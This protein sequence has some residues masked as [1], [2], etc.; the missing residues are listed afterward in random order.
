MVAPGPRKL[1]REHEM[2]NRLRHVPDEVFSRFI[3]FSDAHPNI[4]PPGYMLQKVTM[5]DFV[6]PLVAASKH[7][8][9]LEIGCG[10]G[11][12]SALLSGLGRVTSTELAVPGSFAGADDDVDRHRN[13]VFEALAKGPIDFAYNDGKAI[14][15]RDASFDVVFHNSVIEHV[16][17]PRRFNAEVARVLRPG[18]T[19]ITITGTPL[20]CLFRLVK[21]YLLLLG[22]RA[23]KSL[24][25]ELRSTGAAPSKVSDRLKSIGG[26]E[27]ARGGKAVDMRGTYSRIRHFIESPAYNRVIVENLAAANGMSVETF[28]ASA[29][30]HFDASFWNR[31]RFDLAPRTHGQHYRGAI[32]ELKEWSVDKWVDRSESAGLRVTAV[33]PFRYHHLFETLNDVGLTSRLYHFFAPLIHSANDLGVA[34]PEFASEF[35]L[36]AHKA[37]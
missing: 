29:I 1:I 11:V 22:P 35:I 18:G 3:K 36:V 25:T 31:F 33:I 13:A 4:V 32:D 2:K 9:I 7:A 6:Q 5:F 21:G 37:A 17:D 10:T 15:F 16:D 27:A 8:D 12:H 14:P 28:L 26:E 20:F 34:K 19:S 24:L 30:A 23:L